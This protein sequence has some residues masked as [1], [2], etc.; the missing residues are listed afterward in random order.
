MGNQQML[1]S[2]VSIITG[3]VHEMDLPITSSQLAAWLARA[4]LIQNIFPDLT[5][6]QRE[7]LQTGTTP[8]EWEACFGPQRED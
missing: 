5:P 7:F 8:E 1:I 6:A 4:D 2:R 3:K